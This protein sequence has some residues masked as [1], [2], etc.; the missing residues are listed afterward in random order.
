MSPRPRKRVWS[1]PDRSDR[2]VARL[3]ATA[4]SRGVLMAALLLS[5]LCCRGVG[6]DQTG[7]DGVERGLRAALHPQFREDAAHVRLY[8]L[9]GIVQAV[10]DLLEIGRAS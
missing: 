10:G 7:A 9:L 5:L 2:L 3:S 6:G 8:R 4:S 1:A